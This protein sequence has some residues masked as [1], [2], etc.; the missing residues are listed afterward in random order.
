MSRAGGRPPALR[1]IQ[2]GAC[3]APPPNSIPGVEWIVERDDLSRISNDLLQT[4][5]RANRE[6]DSLLAGEA[7][8][9]AGG[10]RQRLSALFDSI[11]SVESLLSL[12]RW[13]GD[14]A[15][16]E[17]D[18]GTFDLRFALHD[19]LEEHVARAREL[20]I[21]IDTEFPRES[22][23]VAG[24]RSKLIDLIDFSLAE[25]LRGAAPGSVV[26]AK[27]RRSEPLCSIRFETR[28]RLWAGW[29]FRRTGR[30]LARE[31]L[32]QDGGEFRI[33]RDGTAVEIRI[34][35]LPGRMAD[36]RGK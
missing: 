4:V 28:G 2:G 30:L 23:P 15:T 14:G 27:V 22:L 12:L 26:R 33:S 5:H 20:R 1:V 13:Q 35:C 17:T 10:Q 34:P 32:E 21:R 6:I 3:T 19:V 25:M 11:S 36:D 7:G 16:S 8:P 18:G 24:N 9:M 29:R 31:A